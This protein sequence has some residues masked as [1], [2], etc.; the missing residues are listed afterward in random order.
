MCM[1]AGRLF[2]ILSPNRSKQPTA[3]AKEDLEATDFKRGSLWHTPRRQTWLLDLLKLPTLDLQRRNGQQ[4][5]TPAATATSSLQTVLPFPG[6]QSIFLLVT[7]S[8]VSHSATLG[9]LSICHCTLSHNPHFREGKTGLEALHNTW[10]HSKLWQNYWAKEKKPGLGRVTWNICSYSASERTLGHRPTLYHCTIMNG[11]C[12]WLHTSFLKVTFQ[13]TTL[14]Q[15]YFPHV[16]VASPGSKDDILCTWTC[17]IRFY[18]TMV[19]TFNKTPI[20]CLPHI[21]LWYFFK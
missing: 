5:V 16:Q 9:H 18:V 13:V 20:G 17:C 19:L 21:V 15:E 7:G 11:S 3:F 1:D 2:P 12:K 10:F 6:L 14:S 4:A 8:G